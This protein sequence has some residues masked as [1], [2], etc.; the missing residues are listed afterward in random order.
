[1]VDVNGQGEVSVP[2]ARA[3]VALGIWKAVGAG[4]LYVK[5]ES[6]YPR[7]GQLSNSVTGLQ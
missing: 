2:G 3:R 6:P 5:T 7:L 1:M 4:Y